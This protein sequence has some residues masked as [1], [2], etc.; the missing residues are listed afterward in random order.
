LSDSE[1]EATR[2]SLKELTKSARVA[3]DAIFHFE[4][5]IKTKAVGKNQIDLV[6]SAMSIHGKDNP[7]VLF[8]G[9]VLVRDWFLSEVQSMDKYRVDNIDP[10]INSIC[11]GCINVINNFKSRSDGDS[12]VV[13]AYWTLLVTLLSRRICMHEPFNA[14]SPI[15]IHALGDLVSAELLMALSPDA[16]GSA[17]ACLPLLVESTSDA[18]FVKRD[19]AQFCFD[20]IASTEPVESDSLSSYALEYLTLCGSKSED[21]IRIWFV[22]KLLSKT[23][24]LRKVSSSLAIYVNARHSLFISLR[25]V[26]QLLA[27]GLST[28]N[29]SDT[30]SAAGLFAFVGGGSSPGAGNRDRVPG[31]FNTVNLEDLD[32]VFSAY[33]DENMQEGDSE[34]LIAVCAIGRLLCEFYGTNSSA[35]GTAVSTHVKKWALSAIVSHDALVAATGFS[36]IGYIHRFGPES[37]SYLIH[38]DTM[39]DCMQT[40]TGWSFE[41][42]R[43]ETFAFIENLVKRENVD[44]KE[45]GKYMQI[46]IEKFK[47]HP[48]IMSS[49][50]MKLFFF[51]SVSVKEAY[52]RLLDSLMNES[53]THHQLVVVSRVL[54]QMILAVRSRGSLADFQAEIV[55]LE[56][57]RLTRRKINPGGSPVVTLFRNISMCRNANDDVTAEILLHVLAG[58]VGNRSQKF[59]ATVLNLFSESDHMR[60]S[61]VIDPDGEDVS[62]P[63]LAIPGHAGQTFHQD[64]ISAFIAKLDP[65]TKEIEESDHDG[66][67]SRDPQPKD[68]IAVKEAESGWMDS[69]ANWLLDTVAGDEEDDTAPNNIQEKPKMKKKR[70]DEPPVLRPSISKQLSLKEPEPSDHASVRPVAEKAPPPNVPL[71]PKAPVKVPV[72]TPMVKA[73]TKTVPTKMAVKKPAVKTPTVIPKSAPITKPVVKKAV[74]APPKPAPKVEPVHEEAEEEAL[75]KAVEKPKK[76][77]K[78]TE[79]A[80]AS[81]FGDPSELYNTFGGWFGSAEPPKKEKKKKNDE[82]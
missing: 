76:A 33:S 36:L 58:L 39:V 23:Q 61:S 38:P 34:I 53:V 48:G 42:A 10:L 20:F 54:L 59:N 47:F 82:E 57:E 17:L 60:L 21:A 79:T 15:T 46:F 70:D 55:R 22:E 77:K 5:K 29:V 26:A 63:D 41:W 16:C 49:D 64:V 12:L 4:R 13:H 78:T 51:K 56:S 2:Y 81:Y 7:E 1:E 69:A 80:P 31:I 27:I 65:Q 19:I 3:L 72:K 37:V 67:E 40:M 68:D 6:I 62:H 74:A 14:I 32:D 35:R 11:Q 25:F 71:T 24:L 18:C 66:A 43:N 45:T 75:P 30:G 9:A 44:T 8:F 52:V 28:L 73:P 50:E